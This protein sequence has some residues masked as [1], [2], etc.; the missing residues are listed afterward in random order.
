[1]SKDVLVTIL[2]V[3]DVLNIPTEVLNL[4]P[5]ISTDIVTYNINR[6]VDNNLQSSD[7]KCK[8]AAIKLRDAY[9]HVNE[10]HDY[11]DSAEVRDLADTLATLQYSDITV[12]TGLDKLKMYRELILDLLSEDADFMREYNNGIANDVSGKRSAYTAKMD[13][14][15]LESILNKMAQE[16][17]GNPDVL[18]LITRI[19][20]NKSLFKNGSKAGNRSTVL[21]K[22]IAKKDKLK[23]ILRGLDF[24]IPKMESGQN[25]ITWRKL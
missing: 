10:V 22:A 21:R 14:S 16:S 9:A 8:E 25:P 15:N 4:L 6:F 18:A 23:N 5:L 24:L 19:Q 7:A 13:N 20:K 11:L 17:H 2:S 3:D 12:D 1:M